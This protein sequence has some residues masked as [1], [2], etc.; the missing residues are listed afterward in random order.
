VTAT[1]GSRIGVHLTEP[2]AI[3]GTEL[4]V[5]GAG[6]MVGRNRQKQ[7]VALRVFRPKP[8]Q[9]LLVGGL[10]C[11]QLL[12]F[13]ALALGAQLFIQTAREREWVGFLQRA[14]VGREVAAFLPP[15]AAPP[16]SAS[17]TR[18]HFLVVD[19][20]PAMAPAPEVGA[21]WRATLVLREELASWDVG[22][23]QHSDVVVLQRLTEAEAGIAASALG[24]AEAHSWLP[25]IHPEMVALISRARLRWVLLGPTPTEQALLGPL[26][27][28]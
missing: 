12:A 2:E 8:T 13:R 1:P 3:D 26:A 11:A 4:L 10:G 25:R 23:L 22:L 18:P 28:A 15:G 16:A 7:P 17:L 14:G 21:P 27:R 5:G 24:I 19:L 6:L 20:G 9:L